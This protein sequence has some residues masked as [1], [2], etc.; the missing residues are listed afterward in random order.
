[1]SFSS[2]IVESREALIVEDMIR[3]ERFADNPFVTDFPYLKFYAGYPLVA[4]N[5]MAIGA[6][7]IGDSN[8]RQQPFGDRVEQLRCMAEIVMSEMELR[9]EAQQ[10]SE[11]RRDAAQARTDLEMALALSGR[12]EER[13]VGKECRST[14]SANAESEQGG[15]HRG[16]V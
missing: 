3:D 9:R 5:G 13:R 6:L 7:W 16:S 11:E 1:I 15:A 4:P 12:S 8:V 10:R 14:R 2:H